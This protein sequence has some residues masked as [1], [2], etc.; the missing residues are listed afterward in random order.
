MY[1]FKLKWNSTIQNFLFFVL[2]VLGIKP[3]AT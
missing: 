2:V 1:S 3:R